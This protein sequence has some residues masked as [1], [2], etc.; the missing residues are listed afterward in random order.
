MYQNTNNIFR[1]IR[2]EYQGCPLI[3]I[4]LVKALSYG[5]LLRFDV[6]RI[7]QEKKTLQWASPSELFTERKERYGR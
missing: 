3:L 2:F 6:I 1:Y 4:W 7:A 5:V